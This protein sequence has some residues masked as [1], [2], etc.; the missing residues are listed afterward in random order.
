MTLIR[1]FRSSGALDTFLDF[2][3]INISL[4]RSSNPSPLVRACVREQFKIA[5]EGV[6]PAGLRGIML[7][8]QKRIEKARSGGAL[9]QGH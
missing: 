2:V 4:L 9:Y 1:L 3:S 7:I 8:E 6:Y 5:P